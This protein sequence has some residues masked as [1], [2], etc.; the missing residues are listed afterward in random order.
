M[1]YRSLQRD[2]QFNVVLSVEVKHI[3]QYSIVIMN[4]SYEAIESHISE[5]LLSVAYKKNWKFT[6]LAKEFEVS[7]PISKIRT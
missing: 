2:Q 6:D 4:M 1:G 3:D 7:R 5:A